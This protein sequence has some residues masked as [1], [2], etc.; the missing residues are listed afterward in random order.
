MSWWMSQ[1]PRPW[2][3]NSGFGACSF[4]K[5]EGMW[6]LFSRHR[7]KGGVLLGSYFLGREELC[8]CSLWNEEI[9]QNSLGMEFCSWLGTL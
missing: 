3:T 5:G 2:Q 6:D 9:W 7:L 8:H 4:G 1:H